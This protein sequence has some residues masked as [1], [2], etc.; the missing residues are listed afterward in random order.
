MQIKIVQGDITQQPE[1][2]ATVNATGIAFFGIG[3]R[4]GCVAGG[5][6]RSDDD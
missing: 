1:M 6:M 3:N 4:R 2:D 5:R